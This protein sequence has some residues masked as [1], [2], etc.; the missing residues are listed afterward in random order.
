LVEKVEPHAAKN[1]QETRT[2]FKPHSKISRSFRRRMREGTGLQGYPDQSSFECSWGE[3]KKKN[4]SRGKKNR[5]RY[6]AAFKKGESAGGKGERQNLGDF[7]STKS[8]LQGRK[9]LKGLLTIRTRECLRLVSKAKA[10]SKRRT[11]GAQYV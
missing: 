6:F 3:G 4:Q 11:D 5:W 9:G 7:I 8:Y 1:C 2:C 10:R